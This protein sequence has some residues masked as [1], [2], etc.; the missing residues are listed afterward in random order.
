MQGEESN[1]MGM[2]IVTAM[3]IVC[4]VRFKHFLNASDY[5]FLKMFQKN[6]NLTMNY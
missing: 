1:K 4:I 5:K 2:D 3:F 6:F